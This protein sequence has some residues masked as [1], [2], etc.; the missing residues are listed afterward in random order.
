MTISSDDPGLFNINLT[1]EHQVLQRELKFTAQDI[2]QCNDW[3]FDSSFIDFAEKN[4]YKYY[5]AIHGEGED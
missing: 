5:K 1:H 3:A 4:H 2:A